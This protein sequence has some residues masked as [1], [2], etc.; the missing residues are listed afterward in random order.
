[1]ATRKDII[2]QL[3]LDFEKMTVANEYST[4]VGEV[5]IGIFDPSKFTIK[6]GIGITIY[7]DEVIEQLFGLQVQRNLK[8]LVYG[9]IDTNDFEEYKEILDFTKDAE[10][11]LYSEHNTYHDDTLLTMTK[12]NFGGIEN[13][14]GYFIIFFD[15]NYLQTDF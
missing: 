3:K 7:E 13:Q 10:K 9:Y 6:P 11:L 8:G 15:I 4:E 5:K 2:Q 12:I 1:M 14:T